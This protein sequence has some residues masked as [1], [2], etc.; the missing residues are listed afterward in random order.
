MVRRKRI[1]CAAS[2]SV[3]LN[4]PQEPLERDS[5]SEEAFV[6][7]CHFVSCP[8]CIAK[9]Q[10]ECR[11]KWHIRHKHWPKY[12]R[13]IF[14]DTTHKCEICGRRYLNLQYLATHL[15]HAHATRMRHLRHSD[16]SIER[17]FYSRYNRFHC[18]TCGDT[19]MEPYR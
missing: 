13:R 10:T 16:Q 6:S 4:P 3:K 5:G 7:E 11:V 2:R 8:F 15:N 18:D 9:F 19:F 1:Q 14:V 12:R 17:D